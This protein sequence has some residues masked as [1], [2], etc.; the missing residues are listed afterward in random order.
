[1]A[2]LGIMK[3]NDLHLIYM[4]QKFTNWNMVKQHEKLPK[5]KFLPKPCH[6]FQAFK[7]SIKYLKKGM[8]LPI[9]GPKWVKMG[10]WTL[11][12]SWFVWMPQLGSSFFCTF[13]NVERSLVLD[14]VPFANLEIANQRM[15]TSK[16]ALNAIMTKFTISC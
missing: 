3:N 12:L 6:I 9:E 16:V 14:V 15:A 2:Q 11:L 4:H 1:M 7:L 8:E 13:T 10:T 5:F